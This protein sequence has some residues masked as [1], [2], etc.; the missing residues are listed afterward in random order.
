V[1]IF[2]KKQRF[3]DGTPLVSGKTAEGV[4]AANSKK[5][6]EFG[7]Y[8]MDCYRLARLEGSGDGRE[9]EWVHETEDIRITTTHDATLGV[10]SVRR[11]D[12]TR[13]APEPRQRPINCGGGGRLAPS[14][15]SEMAKER[16]YSGALC[17]V[18]GSYTIRPADGGCETCGS[19]PDSSAGGTGR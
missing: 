11:V 14:S 18:C 16:G 8:P 6:L 1:S 3:F 19:A 10:T 13:A 2:H 12:A 7:G 17:A 15:L 4:C 5:M 9:V